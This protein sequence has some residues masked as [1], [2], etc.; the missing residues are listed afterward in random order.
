VEADAL[1]RQAADRVVERLDARARE[2]DVGLTVGSGTIWSQLSAITGSS[3][4]SIS[5][6]STIALYSSRIASAQA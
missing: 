3:I 4:W 5:P 2:A 6:E 1:G